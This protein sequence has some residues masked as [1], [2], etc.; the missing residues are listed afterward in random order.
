M[1]KPLYKPPKT[2]F[3]TRDRWLTFAFALGP[4]AA[5]G[6]L[7]AGYALV[8]TACAQASKTML[9]VST[10]AFFVVALIGAL[11]GWRYHNAFAETDGTLWQE[12]TRWVSMVVTVL[13]IGSALVIVAM[14]IPNVILRSCD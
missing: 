2:E 1:Q 8:P 12:R 14:E 11:I 9:H 13:S 5:L 6:N 4:M 10:A 7:V 3:H